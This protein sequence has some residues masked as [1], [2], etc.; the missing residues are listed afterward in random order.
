M[1]RA[2]LIA[3]IERDASDQDDPWFPTHYDYLGPCH[4]PAEVAARLPAGWTPHIMEHGT[5]MRG[6]WRWACI[7]RR[8]GGLSS[9]GIGKTAEQALADVARR[10]GITLAARAII[11]KEPALA[12][13][14]EVQQRRGGALKQMED[15]K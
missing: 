8:P 3:L 7:L 9:M 4:T 15:G 13:A 6:R 5:D 11:E 12:V 2:D 14:R 10:E 1:T